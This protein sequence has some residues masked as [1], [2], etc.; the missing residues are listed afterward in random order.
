MS[1]RNANAAP[2]NGTSTSADCT[3]TAGSATRARLV[4][5][6][7]DPQH[8]LERRSALSGVHD[9]RFPQR[10]HPVGTRRLGDSLGRLARRDSLLELERSN[11]HLD[12]REPAMKPGSAT[13]AALLARDAATGRADAPDQTLRQ[14]PL[15]RRRDLV[16]R[17]TD[18]D[19]PSD[20][21]R[22]VVRVEG[23]ENEVS[24]ERRLNRDLRGL[25]IANLADQHDVGILPH[26]R[27]QRRREG[28]SGFLVHL[29]LHD[30]RQPVLD[31][32]LDRDDVHAALLEAPQRGV[33]RRRLSRSRWPGDE[34]ETF[35]ALQQL[36]DSF[37]LVGVK[38]HSLERENGRPAVEHS[39]DDLLA[40]RR[41]E[42]SRR[43][44]RPRRR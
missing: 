38:A 18:V 37:E 14:H 36:V 17:H 31:R 25:A 29:H 10:A 16:A 19:E 40:V 26:D 33:E 8:L 32:I 12:E 39:N 22:R 11:E 43:A 27:P 20:G 4:V 15:H 13:V 28:E 9:A 34:D 1:S 35:A 23:R 7:G 44:G 41:R 5:R 42:A 2:L 30:A 6:R 21:A 3:G 24:R